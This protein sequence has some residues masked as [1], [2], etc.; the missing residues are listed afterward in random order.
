[1]AKKEKKVKAEIHL[2]QV[3]DVGFSLKTSGT[4]KDIGEAILSLQAWFITEHIDP[5]QHSDY[6]LYVLESLNRKNKK[7]AI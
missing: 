6:L 7:E 1:M 4:T 3:D 2:K 5:K